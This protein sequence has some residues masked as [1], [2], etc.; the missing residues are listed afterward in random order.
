MSAQNVTQLLNVD[1][2]IYSRSRLEPLARVL[3]KKLFIHYVGWEK[4]LYSAHLSLSGFGQSADALILHLAQIIRKLPESAK[5][6]W[7]SAKS[8][9]FNI[10]I[11]A[12]I[13]PK[14]YEIVISQKSVGVLAE[15]GGSIVVT[16][17]PASITS[18]KLAK[19]KSKRRLSS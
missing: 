1:L 8:R 19:Q 17:Y 16:T 13:R 6:L 4:D 5:K 2:D 9:E 14:A 12:G 15:L 10:G 11:Q 3:E 7:G 18:P